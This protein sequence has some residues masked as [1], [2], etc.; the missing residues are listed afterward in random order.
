MVMSALREPRPE[1][2]IP[3]S[4][5]SQQTVAAMA[6]QEPMLFVAGNFT[7]IEGS[8]GLHNRSDFALVNVWSNEIMPLQANTSSG[9][10]LY[11]VALEPGLD[12]VAIGGCFTKINNVARRNLA[13]LR[14]SNGELLPWNPGFDGCVKSLAFS[15]DGSKLFVGGAFTAKLSAIDTTS[16]NLISTFNPRPNGEVRALEADGNTNGVF[17]GGSFTSICGSTSRHHLAAVNPSG[18][19]GAAF[20]N[21]SNEVLALDTDF[22]GT[23]VY[24]ATGGSAN[25]VVTYNAS[26]HAKRWDGFQAMGDAQAVSFYSDRVYWGFHEGLRSATDGY[27][28]ARLNAADGRL[29]ENW[30][31][32]KFPDNFL[33]VWSVLVNSTAGIMAVG[34][35]FHQVNTSTHRHLAVFSM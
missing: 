10:R 24:A 35:D 20:S 7:Q 14:V 29:D 34:G 2:E 16:G 23:T 4:S 17:A 18:S 33:G 6:L 12:L 9:E 3:T 27:R 11:S 25:R 26:T 22:M 31:V 13:V 19:C 30:D 5:S 32:P 15:S 21:S 8:N 28:M 1:I